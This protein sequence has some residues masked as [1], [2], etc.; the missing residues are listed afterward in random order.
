MSPTKPPAFRIQ[1][2]LY[3]TSQPELSEILGDLANSIK[4]QAG[5][6]QERSYEIS[7]QEN[8]TTLGHYSYTVTKVKGEDMELLNPA[9]SLLSEL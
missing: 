3:A 4:L 5:L 8:L 9:L 7:Q 1:L 2:C 6:H